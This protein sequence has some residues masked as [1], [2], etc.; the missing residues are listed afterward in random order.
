MLAR[1]AEA[2]AS[3]RHHM[4]A[5]VSPRGISARNNGL[6]SER[7]GFSQ[8]G[9]TSKTSNKRGQKAVAAAAAAARQRQAH[10]SP[11]AVEGAEMRDMS[12]P[13]MQP[14]SRARY[15]FTHGTRQQPATAKGNATPPHQVVEASR[16]G[17][18]L[19]EWVWPLKE[20]AA[21]NKMG[22]DHTEVAGVSPESVEKVQDQGRVF[23]VEGSGGVGKRPSIVVGKVCEPIRPTKLD[24]SCAAGGAG[25]SIWWQSAQFA[26][27]C[28]VF[29]F[30]RGQSP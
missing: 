22:N 27:L 17:R 25:T 10:A 19:A 7:R 21:S 26:C 8:V 14:L 30:V 1:S 4:S 29:S 28:L 16:R 23:G 15:D 6:S 5:M 3:P 24:L 11:V 18:P 9:G 13:E 12:P 2:V 20:S